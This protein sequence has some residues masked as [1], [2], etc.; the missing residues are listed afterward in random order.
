MVKIWHK[1]GMKGK[2]EFVPF[3]ALLAPAPAIGTMLVIT[4]PNGCAVSLAQNLALLIPGVRLDDVKYDLRMPS[5]AVIY[6]MLIPFCTAR[7]LVEKQQSELFET[8][9]QVPEEFRIEDHQVFAK[10]RFNK[11]F[12]SEANRTSTRMN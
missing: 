3:F 5:V 2:E 12:L 11:Y 8:I 9:N 10:L 6:L 7:R 1:K 4:V